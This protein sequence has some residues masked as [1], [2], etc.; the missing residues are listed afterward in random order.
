MVGWG[1]PPPV[2]EKSE[3]PP[4]PPPPPGIKVCCSRENWLST[5][6][7]IWKI[8]WHNYSNENNWSLTIQVWIVA[9]GSLCAP[10][11]IGR[12]H[13]DSL[14]GTSMISL[15]HCAFIGFIITIFRAILPDY[16]INQAMNSVVLIQFIYTYITSSWTSKYIF[17]LLAKAYLLFMVYAPMYLQYSKTWSTLGCFLAYCSHC[18][19]QFFI[20]HTNQTVA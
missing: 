7:S 16:C 18:I 1:T 11:V 15:L 6:K 9:Y 8:S 17:V 14:P 2:E 10:K 12:C 3:C 4:P 20:P 13:T 19:G 5:I